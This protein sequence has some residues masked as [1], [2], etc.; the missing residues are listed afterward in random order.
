M[1]ILALDCRIRVGQNGPARDRPR[2]SLLS[3]FRSMLPISSRGVW[4]MTSAGLSRSVVQEV[5]VRALQLRKP[6]GPQD[7]QGVL[8][9]RADGTM[10]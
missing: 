7:P 9:S 3:L 6:V 10:R 1:Y 4:D 5:Q 2:D 8:M